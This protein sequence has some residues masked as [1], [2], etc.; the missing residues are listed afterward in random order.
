MDVDK[1]RELVDLVSRSGIAELEVETDD[2][3]LRIS[4]QLPAAAA[5]VAA[6]M[7]APVATPTPAPPAAAAEP[8]PGPS[9]AASGRPVTSPIVGTFYRSPEPGSPPFVEIGQKVAPG[10]T[11]CIV[12]AM[13]V[14]NEIEAEFAGTVVEACLEDGQPVEA[15]AVLFRIEPS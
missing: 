2:M 12:E 13:K 4:A 9:P 8:S 1:I 7:T 5:P 3:N 14:M 15:E 6:A 10:D 11:L